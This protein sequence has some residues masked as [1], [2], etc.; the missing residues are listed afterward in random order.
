MAKRKL[1][2]EDDDYLV[3]SR[4]TGELVNTFGTGDYIVHKEQSEYAKKHIINFNK[5]E[6]FVKLY[7]NALDV[8]RERLTPTEYVLAISLA[9]FVSYQDCILRL[10][11]KVLTMQDIAEAL[12]MEYPTIRRLIPQ[13]VSKGVLGIFKVGSIEDPKHMIRVIMSNPYVYVRGQDVC[14]TTISL[15]EDTGWDKLIKVE[16]KK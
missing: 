15:F 9:K 3:T 4:Q 12:N 7:D 13:L 8:L 1:K 11:K 10:D 5:G 6:G 14:K 16:S 2:I